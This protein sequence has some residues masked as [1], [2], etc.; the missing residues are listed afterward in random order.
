MPARHVDRCLQYVYSAVPTLLTTHRATRHDDAMLL[1][2]RG[3]AGQQDR[4]YPHC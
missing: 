2:K 3:V 1:T 4:T